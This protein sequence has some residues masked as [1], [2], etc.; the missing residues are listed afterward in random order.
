MDRLEAARSTLQAG[1][2]LNE[3]R[4]ARWPLPTFEAILGLERFLA[5]QWDDALA[6]LESCLALAGELGEENY[7]VNLANAIVALISFHRDDLNR[8]A[9]AERAANQDLQRRG[10]QFARWAVWPQA[11]LQEASGQTAQALETLI[12]PLQENARSGIVAEY[13]VMGPDLVRLAVAEGDIGLARRVAAAVADVS[14][15]NDVAWL[16]GAALRCQGLADNDAETLAAAADA[17][18]AATRPLELALASEDA[19]AAFVKRGDSERALPLLDR[20]IAIYEGIDADRDLA[21]ANAVLR[22]A[23]VRRGVRGP[24]NRPRFG[25]QSLTP[26]ERTVVGLVA[27]G[28]S[29]PQIGERLFISRR[30]VQTHLA[31]VFA[32]LGLSSRAQLAAQVA[33]RR[34]AG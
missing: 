30:T 24:R 6:E 22:R 12:T 31:H 14:S 21:R 19:A 25:W 15:R 33:R 16:R 23:G 5:G 13:P 29:N 2:R 1:R 17:Y 4:G 11:L 3:E 28:L 26:S 9:A 7:T 20:A 8:A 18:A 27:D 32:K 10:A 34:E